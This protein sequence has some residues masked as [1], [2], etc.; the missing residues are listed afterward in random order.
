[1]ELYLD[2]PIDWNF[3]FE[4]DIQQRT[5][6]VEITTFAIELRADWMIA[7][8]TRTAALAA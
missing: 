3:V 8:L 6:R 7:I 1:M 4:S 5:A 2:K